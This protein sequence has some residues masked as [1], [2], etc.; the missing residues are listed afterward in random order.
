[1]EQHRPREPDPAGHRVLG[2]R[3]PGEHVQQLLGVV[4][5]A[6]RRQRVAAPPRRAT[7]RPAAPRTAPPASAPRS[8]PSAATPRRPSNRRP[9]S[10]NPSSTYQTTIPMPTLITTSSSISPAQRKRSAASRRTCRGAS[11][12]WSGAGRRREITGALTGS[13]CRGTPAGTRS[14]CAAG[15]RPSRRRAGCAAGPGGRGT[16]TPTRSYTSR[17]CQSAVRHTPA[18]RRHLRQ[19]ARLVVLP[20]RQD[21]LQREPPAGVREARTG[22]RRLPGAARSRPW[23]PSSGPAPGNRRR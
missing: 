22:G 11:S 16:C 10:G 6:L 12:G 21:H 7:A 1:M 19:L 4:L 17:S 20:A 5:V 8:R 23:R 3:H 15:G 14:P 2:E 9:A 18:T 13:G